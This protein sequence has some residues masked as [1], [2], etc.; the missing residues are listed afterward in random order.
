[1]FNEELVNRA[2][3]PKDGFALIKTL[4]TKLV[5]NETVDRNDA[6]DECI[7][8]MFGEGDELENTDISIHDDYTNIPDRDDQ[9]D[10]QNNDNSNVFNSTEVTSTSSSVPKI[11]LGN[12]FIL[13]R[14]KMIEM[15]ISLVRERK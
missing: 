13:G 1:M 7:I 15:K 6:L 11:S 8:E 3:I 2:C 9:P 14:K 10:E 5:S 12:V 4:K